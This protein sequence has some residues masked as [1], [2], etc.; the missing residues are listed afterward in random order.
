MNFTVSGA[1]LGKN[2]AENQAASINIKNNTQLKESSGIYGAK[3]FSGVL[4]YR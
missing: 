1:E 2:A 4:E 3:S